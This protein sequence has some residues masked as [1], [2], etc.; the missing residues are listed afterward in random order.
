MIQLWVVTVWPAIV[1]VTCYCWYVDILK[2]LLLLLLL[3]PRALLAESIW[4]AAFNGQASILLWCHYSFASNISIS[5]CH[6]SSSPAW[7]G[8]SS[9]H[10][11][12]GSW[13]SWMNENHGCIVAKEDWGEWSGRRADSEQTHTREPSEALSDFFHTF[14]LLFSPL[15]LLS[16]PLHPSFSFHSVACLC[17]NLSFLLEIVVKLQQKQS[18]TLPLTVYSTCHK[19]GIPQSTPTSGAS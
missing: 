19:T 17:V 16:L 2:P 10:P 14:S 3:L 13:E 5:I 6:G 4:A 1:S 12:N 7:S 11:V 15:S 9:L 18:A 8:S